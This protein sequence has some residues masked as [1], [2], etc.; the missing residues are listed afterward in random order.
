MYHFHLSGL[1]GCSL[2][3]SR[4]YWTELGYHLGVFVPFFHCLSLLLWLCLWCCSTLRF[5]YVFVVVAWRHFIYWL[6]L[7]LLHTSLLIIGVIL[8]EFTAI[9]YTSCSWQL[10]FHICP[11]Q[12]LEDLYIYSTYYYILLPNTLSYGTYVYKYQ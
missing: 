12:Q 4:S 8:S 11:T 2:P 3:Q 5:K 9:T 7:P 1:E 10:N 6:P